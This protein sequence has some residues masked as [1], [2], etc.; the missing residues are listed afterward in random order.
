MLLLSTNSVNCTSGCG[1]FYYND[2]YSYGSSAMYLSRIEI[3]TTMYGRVIIGVHDDTNTSGHRY[4]MNA[5]FF[6][7]RKNSAQGGYWAASSTVDADLDGLSKEIEETIGSC[8]SVNDSPWNGVGIQGMSCSDYK[9]RV[10]SFGGTWSPAD[11]DNDGL[12]DAAEIFA[13][14]VHCEHA[15]TAPYYNP[16]NCQKFG[17]HESPIC[18]GGQY[19]VGS[20]LSSLS[21]PNPFIYDIFVF[22]D[23][24]KSG[25][26][27]YRVSSEG[28]SYLKS[29]WHDSSISCWDD[30]NA[31]CEG[32]ED[33]P[34]M[35]NAHVYSLQGTG[36]PVSRHDFVDGDFGSEIG[37][38][39][40]W[41]RGDRK[42]VV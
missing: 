9:D 18:V 21:D 39:A 32:E 2:D 14:G 26:R 35:F 24:I 6:H 27:E 22:N 11:S 19:C 15:P 38:G 30:S 28:Q 29:A 31:P 34:Y 3:P 20:D 25:S 40:V 17:F 23:Y 8:D 16:G 10:E 41:V 42:S 12:D 33:L 13:V 36:L 1:N 37:G 5:R 7:D 4:K